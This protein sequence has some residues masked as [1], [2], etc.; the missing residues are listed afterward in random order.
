M[1]HQE[2]VYKGHSAYCSGQPTAYIR[3]ST[4]DI[5]LTAVDSQQ[6]ILV[7]LQG[8]F[9]SQPIVYRDILLTAVDSQQSTLVSLQGTFCLLQWAANSLH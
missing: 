9:C 2:T 7:S 6:S 3:Q 1:P 5:L 8:T 4:R